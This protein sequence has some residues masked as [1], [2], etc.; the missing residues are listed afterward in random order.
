MTDASRHDIP[1]RFPRVARADTVDGERIIPTLIERDLMK[2][3]TLA[4][5]TGAATTAALLV[6]CA[7]DSTNGTTPGMDHGTD[8]S[9][10]PSAGAVFND[11][12]VAFAMNMIVR[13][14]FGHAKLLIRP[15]PFHNELY[16]IDSGFALSMTI[17]PFGFRLG[18]KPSG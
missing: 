8:S 2:I 13:D 16:C 9:S 17:E 14:L 4:L 10:T 12:D 1:P 6:G 18:V 11:A 7:S 5:L 15:V 3:R